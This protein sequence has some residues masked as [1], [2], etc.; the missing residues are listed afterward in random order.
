M[1]GQLILT[2][3]QLLTNKFSFLK[4][5]LYIL[6]SDNSIKVETYWVCGLLFLEIIKYHQMFQEANMNHHGIKITDGNGINFSFI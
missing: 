4:N 5:K 3:T 6:I 1:Y 2:N